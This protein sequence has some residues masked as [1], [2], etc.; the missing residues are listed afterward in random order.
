MIS[1]GIRELK[2]KLSHYVAINA[3]PLEKVK[4]ESG[5][6][7]AGKSALRRK[8]FSTLMTLNGH[9]RKSAMWTLT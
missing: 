6:I 4:L 1:A 5:T 9:W 7:P 2:N 8:G 3:Q